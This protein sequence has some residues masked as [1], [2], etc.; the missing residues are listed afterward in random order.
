MKWPRAATCSCGRAT[1]RRSAPGHIL[2]GPRVLEMLDTLDTP[3]F[4]LVR[5]C[6]EDDD[7]LG[8]LLGPVHHPQA[9]PCSCDAESTERTHTIAFELR[10]AWFVH[11]TYCSRAGSAFASSLASALQ[12]CPRLCQTCRYVPRTA[13]PCSP[14]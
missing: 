12:S 14:V 1:R 13:L 7:T 4:V 5:R 10:P 11:G 9:F 6:I 2:S 8:I 3:M